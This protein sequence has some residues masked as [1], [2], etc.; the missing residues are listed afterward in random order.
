M[1]VNQALIGKMADEMYKM[2][3]EATGLKK[4]KP[5]DLF[6]AMKQLHEKEDVTTRDAKQALRILID[7][8]KL[9]YT[10]FGGTFVEIPHKEGAAND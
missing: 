6:K 1:S 7:S 9:V 8:G 5:Q 3:E 10:Y 2:V 4:L